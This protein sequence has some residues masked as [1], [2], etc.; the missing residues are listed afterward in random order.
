MD[1][2][3]VRAQAHATVIEKK[4]RF[5]AH[6]YPVQR[7]EDALALLDELRS[8]YY[9][10]THNVYAY[11]LRDQQTARYSDDGEPSQSAGMPVLDVIQKSGLYDVLIVVTRYF[12][13]TLLGVGGLVRTYTAAAK[14]GV[15]EAGVVEMRESSVLL[16]S[17]E[18]S[19]FGKAKNIILE[20]GGV[21]DDTEFG[22]D[23]TVTVHI[24]ASD[25]DRLKDA[26]VQGTN[27]NVTLRDLSGAYF[28]YKPD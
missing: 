4:S 13:G 27:D 7:E 8:Q 6:V 15:D 25:G 26:L 10:A 17:M 19:L 20:C 5:I 3:T 16:V 11:R 28:E 14:A 21:I 12:G 9:D 18:Y 23:V 22:A 1:Y 2:K 24:P